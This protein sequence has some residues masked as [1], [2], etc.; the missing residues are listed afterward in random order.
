M[1]PSKVETRPEQ[2]LAASSLISLVSASSDDLLQDVG[3][4]SVRMLAE[5]RIYREL[6]FFSEIDME[7]IVELIARMIIKIIK[8]ANNK[9]IFL[10]YLIKDN[11]KKLQ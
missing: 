9:C 10:F 4:L 6:S 8:I 3:A 5:R 11:P 7:N 2:I 1:S